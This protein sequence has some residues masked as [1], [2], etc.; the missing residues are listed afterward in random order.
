MVLPITSIVLLLNLED[1]F[2]VFKQDVF[3]VLG[4]FG[5]L[6]SNIIVFYLF[7]KL[8]DMYVLEKEMH[9]LENRCMSLS[10][11]YSAS[12]SFLHDVTNRVFYLNKLDGD[13][14]KYEV[15]KLCTMLFQQFRSKQTICI[16]LQNSISKYES[17]LI[18]YGISLK[19]D[20]DYVEFDNSEIFDC[21]LEMGIVACSSVDE[22]FITIKSTFVNQCVVLRMC[23]AGKCK[24]IDEIRRNVDCSKVF[25]EWNGFSEITMVFHGVD[26]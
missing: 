21:L 1:Y 14:L 3:V 24:E 9:R 22:R 4:L 25:Y 16:A 19:V 12:A 2:G 23:C 10:N 6:F 7:F 17:R 5:V 8:L 20:M 18:E 11:L 15:S 13:A 26:V